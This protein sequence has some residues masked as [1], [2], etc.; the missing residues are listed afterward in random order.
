MNTGTNSAFVMTDLKVIYS[1]DRLNALLDLIKEWSSGQIDLRDFRKRFVVNFSSKIQG[2]PLDSVVIAIEFLFCDF[3]PKRT[4]SLEQLQDS[5]VTVAGVAEAM[6][7][8]RPP[9]ERRF[10][11]VTHY[12]PG[13]VPPISN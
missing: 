8:S 7:G 5:I 9:S 4:L 11:R 2:E 13:E 12:G 6:Q 3:N 10:M 1:P